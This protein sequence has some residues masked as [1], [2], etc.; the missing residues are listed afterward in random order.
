MFLDERQRET[1]RRRKERRAMKRREGELDE[2][3]M[4]RANKY[5]KYK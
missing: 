2:R 1:E 5:E 3:G 4:T